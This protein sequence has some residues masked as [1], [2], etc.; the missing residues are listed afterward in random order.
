MILIYRR[1]HFFDDGFKRLPM[2]VNSVAAGK[3]LIILVFGF[4]PF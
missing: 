2:L 4:Y 3:V 1:L